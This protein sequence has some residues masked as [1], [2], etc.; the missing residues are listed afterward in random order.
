MY[1]T[2]FLGWLHQIITTGQ[3]TTA[4]NYCLTNLEARDVKLRCRQCHVP[5][6]GSRGEFSLTFFQLSVASSNLWHSLAQRSVT[7]DSASIFMFFSSV[8]LYVQISLCYNTFRIQDYILKFW[9][10]MNFEETLFNPYTNQQKYFNINHKFNILF[11]SVQSLSCVRLCDPM[12]CSTPGLPVHCQL[13]AFT[14][15]YVH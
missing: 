11:C 8:C 7:L 2:S 13:L 5:S 1:D 14:Q 10:N 4:K 15:T 9:E 3:L 6:E 12:D